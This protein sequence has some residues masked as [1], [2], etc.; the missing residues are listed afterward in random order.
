MIS[1][2]IVDDEPLARQVLENYIGRMPGLTVAGICANAF[3]AYQR[4]Q[5]TAVDLLFLD[6]KMPAMNG[7]DLIKSLKQ[8]PKLIFT[9][10]YA[11]YAAESYELNAVDYLLK[12][13]SFER[14]GTAIGKFL[15]LNP[16]KEA[17][18][19]KAYL[20]IRCENQLVRIGHAD[21]LYVEARKDYLKFVTRQG[22]H[23]THMTMKA[24]VGLLPPTEF[25]RVH[26]SYLVAKAA[27][28]VAGRRSVHIGT[29][30]VPVSENCQKDLFLAL[31]SGSLN[32]G[33]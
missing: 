18:P 31:N 19:A 33:R 14:L 25:V 7:I 11:Q 5:T 26:R 17:A 29:V 21:I 8:P 27:I 12:P 6:I 28:T 15:K 32:N 30:E 24:L 4:L 13:F 20:Y 2:L 1:C 23:L 9:T 3:E 10:A 22:S 16:A